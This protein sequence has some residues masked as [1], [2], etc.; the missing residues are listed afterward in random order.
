MEGDAADATRR[1]KITIPLARYWDCL[2]EEAQR[3]W[4]IENP[5]MVENG[6]PSL[7]RRYS[8]L[9]DKDVIYQI[10]VSRPSGN[11]EVLAEFRYLKPNLITDVSYESRDLPGPYKGDVIRLLP[12]LDENGIGRGAIRLETVLRRVPAAEPTEIK[13]EAVSSGAAFANAASAGVAISLVVNQISACV[14]RLTGPIT[15]VIRDE[16]NRIIASTDVSLGQ[17][18]RELLSVPRPAVQVVAWGDGSGVSTSGNNLFLV[19]TDSN[20]RLHIRIFDPSG[21]LVTDTDETQLPAGRAAAIAALKLQLPGLLRPHV[22][23]NAEI[24]QVINQATVIVGQ[25]PGF[26]RYAEACIGLDQL[27]ELNPQSTVNNAAQTLT[28]IGPI[29][30]AKKDRIEQWAKTTLFEKT[31]RAL[32]AAEQTFPYPADAANPVQADST[33]AATRFEIT[34]TGFTWKALLTDEPLPAEITALIALRDKVDGTGALVYPQPVRDALDVLLTILQDAN[35]RQTVIA[36][37]VIEPAWR[38]RP[39]QATLAAVLQPML[40]VGN[41]VIAFEGMMTQSEGDKLL[42]LTG[43][44]APDQQ[45]VLRLYFASLNSGLAGGTLKVR[46]RRGSAIPV[47]A[48]IVCSLSLPN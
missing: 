18:L 25:V 37:D 2:P 15:Q 1:R 35:Q 17:A 40:M 45:A 20:S 36:L 8:S 42:R 11:V 30:A 26:E 21:N 10:I 43:L 48:E 13:F 33:I 4:K 46:T 34:P 7:K 29:S 39:T 19:G 47:D 23:T 24:D 12:P 22:L 5:D 44:T 32:L 41:A 6:Q 16:I 14:V 38:P 28:W 31:L 27:R 9:P 3:R